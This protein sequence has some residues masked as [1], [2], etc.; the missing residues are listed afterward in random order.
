MVPQPLSHLSR[1]QQIQHL[2]QRNL[3]FLPRSLLYRERCSIHRQEFL[4]THLDGSNFFIFAHC[5]LCPACYCCW[6][7]RHGMKVN[8]L[9]MIDKSL[10]TQRRAKS[11]P[12]K[13]STRICLSVRRNIAVSYNPISSNI[14]IKFHDLTRYTTKSN[15]LLVSIRNVI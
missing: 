2:Q 10:F 13:Q 1:E 8:H 14:W 3:P 11:R 6:S 12:I 4:L 15:I 7:S 9:N 5:S